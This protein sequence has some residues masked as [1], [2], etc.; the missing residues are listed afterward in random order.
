MFPK[1]FFF[2]FKCHD[3]FTTK[4]SG[5][6]KIIRVSENLKTDLGRVENLVQKGENAG[7]QHFLLFPQCFPRD[8][9]TGSIK[10]LS[11]KGL[12]N[13]NKCLTVIYKFP[14]GR[15]LNLPPVIRLVSLYHVMIGSGFPV[16]W[17]VIV[18]DWPSATLMLG[19][20]GTII[21]GFSA[22]RKVTIN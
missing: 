9:F 12:S 21:V 4:S 20:G 5:Q 1:F 17:Q 13:M 11:G 6:G 3:M 19:G 8:S 10:W 22:V 14:L 18:T 16:T 15:I 7:Y 2:F